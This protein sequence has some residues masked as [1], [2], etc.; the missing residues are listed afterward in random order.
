MDIFSLQFL[1]AL[2]AIILID[3][4]LAGDNALV[5]ALAARRL[6]LAEQKRAIFWGTLG[7]IAIRGLMTFS[8]VWLLRIPGLQLLGGLLLIW[9]A[10]K[11]VRQ[12][13]S[14]DNHETQIGP[15]SFWMAMRTIIVADAVM[16]IDNVLGVAATAQG[17]F[18]LVMLG[19]LISIPIVVWFSGLVLKLVERYPAIVYLAAGLLLWTAGKM[20]LAE[21]LLSGWF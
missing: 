9:I 11:L 1:Y 13:Q 3:L 15:S 21:P 2:S 16:G 4:V 19:L 6:P 7:A 10:Y 14:V 12:N 18:I 20:I 5:I 17:S 8:V